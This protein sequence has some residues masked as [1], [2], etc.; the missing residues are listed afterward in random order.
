[1][2][3]YGL[4]CRKNTESK[5]PKGVKTKNGRIMLLSKCEV[6]GSKKPKLIKE[7]ELSWIWSSF[8][9]KTPL[10]KIPIVGPLFLGVLN[11]SI[12][13]IQWME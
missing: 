9:I 4:K 10:S 7:Q 11:K 8:A 12:Q 3:S 1:M 2:L 5:N 13:G 6:C